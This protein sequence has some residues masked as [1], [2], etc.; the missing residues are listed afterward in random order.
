MIGSA[1][2]QDD[3]MVVDGS[4]GSDWEMV[5]CREEGLWL[6]RQVFILVESENGM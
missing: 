6:R 4:Q 1:G 3:L 2:A 5:C